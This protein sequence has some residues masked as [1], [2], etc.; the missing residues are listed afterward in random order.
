MMNKELKARWVAALRSGKY[1]QGQGYLRVG[2]NFCCLGVLCDIIDSKGWT[3]NTSPYDGSQWLV[4]SI[5]WW[6]SDGD[7]CAAGALPVKVL[8]R[9]NLFD[10]Q[11]E[12]VLMDMND[13]GKTFEEIA[14]YI[15]GAKNV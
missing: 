2:D 15:E 8:N 7:G 6:W 5:H 11:E 1:A 13:S 9:I 10:E 3:P 4:D 14:L 12:F